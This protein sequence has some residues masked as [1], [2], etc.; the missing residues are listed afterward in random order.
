MEAYD[1]DTV[2]AIM[3]MLKE[4][5]IPA[6]HKDKFLQIKELIVA[7]DREELLNIL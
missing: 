5:R 7:V 4:Y 2:D 6:S 3:D 1:F